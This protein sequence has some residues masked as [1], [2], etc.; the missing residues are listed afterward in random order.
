MIMPYFI[1]LVGPSGSGKSAVADRLEQQGIVKR[2][3]MDGYYKSENDCAKTSDGRTNYDV[4]ESVDLDAIARDLS[5][6]KQGRS[7]VVPVYHRATHRR[8]GEETFDPAPVVLAEG[9]FLFYPPALRELFDLRIWLDV[10]VTLTRARRAQRQQ[11]GFNLSYYNEVVVPGQVEFVLP[12]K[13]FAHEV[14][15]GSRPFEE[16]VQCAKVICLNFK[17]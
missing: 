8:I 16:V 5:T 6:L 17:K 9:L 14:I 10:P 4:P 15:D 13:Q 3:R 2:F 7:V 1:G 12:T 11:N